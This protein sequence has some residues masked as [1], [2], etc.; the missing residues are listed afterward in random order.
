MFSKHKRFSVRSVDTS[1]SC[2]LPMIVGIY[3]WMI[4][5]K[6]CENKSGTC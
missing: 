4:K 5:G 2:L 6:K 3:W 1:L